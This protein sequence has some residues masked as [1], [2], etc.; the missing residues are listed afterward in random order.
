MYQIFSFALAAIFASCALAAPLPTTKAL[1]K[2]TFRVPVPARF[3]LK[4]GYRNPR[5]ELVKTYAKYG[6]EIIL[7]NPDDFWGQ[8]LGGDGGSGDG[9]S[10]SA[11]AP[12][13]SS[14]V[15]QSSNGDSSDGS[16]PA[17]VT[18]TATTYAPAASTA[19]VA[20]PASSTASSSK[21]N[22]DTGEVAADPEPNESEYLSPV[23]IGGQTLHLDFDTG[24]ADL[25]VF[26]ADL[27]SSETSGHSLFDPSKSST[28]S[29]YEGGSWQIQYGDGSS[30]SG[31]VGFDTVNIGGATATKQA[32]EL[33]T[34]IS[35][36]FE[37]D[38]NNDGLVGLGFSNINT[39]KPQ[40]QK[41][42]WE[43]IKDDLAQPVFTANLEDNASGT[44]TFGEIDSSEYTGDIYYTDID[45]SN[46]FWEFSSTS[47][48]INGQTAQN[49]GASPAI[50]DTGTSLLLLDDA[51]VS[52]YYSAVSGAQQSES[53]GGYIYD[54]SA[55]LPSLG[56]A[57]GDHIVTLNGADLTFAPLGDGTCFGGLQSNQGQGLQIMGDV[58][59]KQVFAV[60]DGGNNRFGVAAKA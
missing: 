50:A 32:V 20:P 13:T 24:S 60:F 37:Q 18:V 21:D 19:S 10:A 57:I 33:A 41:T 7:T 29:D 23:S 6:W 45:N 11:P 59:F 42:F 17:V 9:S 28:W 4:R 39:V 38:V 44:Y 35:G 36:S 5:N 22:G 47:Y 26:S 2:R 25:W 40:A 53:Q 48:A 30:A 16:N 3:G 54:C 12:A 43:N 56:V 8:L 1:A 46:G 15:P 58:L 31:T 49:S 55:T 34:S 14:A 52:A 51:V 27:P